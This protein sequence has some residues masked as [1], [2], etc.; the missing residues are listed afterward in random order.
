MP[1]TITVKGIGR[2]SARPDYVVLSMS[3]ESKNMNYDRAMELASQHI[4][5]L[6]ETICAIG[7]EKSDL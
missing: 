5:H 3:L 2:A 7:F 1:R 4:Q 6:T